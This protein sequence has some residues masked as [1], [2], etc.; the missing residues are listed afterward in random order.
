MVAL[1]LLAEAN[2]VE[3]RLYAILIEVE[4][5]M[6]GGVAALQEAGAACSLPAEP[7]CLAARRPPLP[8]PPAGAPPRY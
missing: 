7:R 6:R 3:S 5:R 4:Q 8:P 2:I 1:K